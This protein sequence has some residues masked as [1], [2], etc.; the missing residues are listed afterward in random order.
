MSVK[1]SGPLR[2]KKALRSNRGLKQGKGLARTKRQTRS[3]D[4]KRASLAWD[5]AVKRRLVQD[6]RHPGRYVCPVCGKSQLVVEFH[7][8]HIIAKQAIK[9]AVRSI[10]YR[11][12]LNVEE[13]ERLLRRLLWDVRNGLACCKWCHSRHTDAVRRIPRKL[14][15]RFAFEFA[16]ELGLRWMIE[17]DY[18]A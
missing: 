3:Q 13:H 8:H 18:P 15:P 2:R 5:R 7:S 10:V 17:R 4:T 9:K 14:L 12:R 1:R 6:K 16:D 11:D